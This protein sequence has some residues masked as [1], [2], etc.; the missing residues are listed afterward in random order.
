[1][2][3]A[4]NTRTLLK[5]CPVILAGL[6]AV[7]LLAQEKKLKWKPEDTEVYTPEPPVVTPGA[8]VDEA[9]PSDAVV[10][11][12]GKDTDQWVKAGSDKPATWT[13]VDGTMKV[14]KKGGNIE[15]QAEVQGLPAARRMADPH[16]HRGQGAG[17]RQQ[18]CFPRLHRWRRCRVRTAGAG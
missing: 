12:N 17:P 7:P 13:V 6:I 9:P 18:R 14:D 11:F 1:M 10:L 4:P 8:A 5:I 16:R 3:F 15:N 2:R